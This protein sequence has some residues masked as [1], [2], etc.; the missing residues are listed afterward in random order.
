MK[1]IAT[2][3]A[4]ALAIVPAIA[5]AQDEDAPSFTGARIGLEASSERISIRRDLGNIGTTQRD[6]RSSIGYRGYLGYDV[7]LGGVVIGG[8]AGI[9]GGGKTVRQNG[10]RGQ[11]LVDPGLS[12]DVSARAGVV[13]TPGVMLYARGGYRW[14]QTDRTTIGTG[15]NPARVTVEQTDGG[16]TYGAGVEA[17]VSKHIVVRA[18]YDRTPYDRALRANKI[19]IGAAFKF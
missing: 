7:D 19:A 6:T 17:I 12:Y 3:A 10:T 2:A 8:E 9:A 1:T 14:L 11:Y 5:H 13:V 4:I 16:L 15:A 18:E